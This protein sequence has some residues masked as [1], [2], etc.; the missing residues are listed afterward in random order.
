MNAFLVLAIL[1]RF[2]VA[3]VRGGTV[4]EGGL[5]GSGVVTSVYGSSTL[6]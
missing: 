1:E 2:D 4:G 6:N 3:E 5:S